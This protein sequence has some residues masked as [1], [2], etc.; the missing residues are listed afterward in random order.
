[1]DCI[2]Q[3]MSENVHYQ[4]NKMLLKYSK[5]Y[6]KEEQEYWAIYSL[7]PFLDYYQKILNHPIF[8]NPE[9]T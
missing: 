1:M 3:S 6:R 8:Q 2:N 4:F 5:N 7:Q 9:I